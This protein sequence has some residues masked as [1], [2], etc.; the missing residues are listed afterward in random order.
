MKPGQSELLAALLGLAAVAVTAL[1]V[2]PAPVEHAPTRSQSQEL[3]AARQLVAAPV[4][5]LREG[6]TVAQRAESLVRVIGRSTWPTDSLLV[7]EDSL[8][9]DWK[10]DVARTLVR[11]SWGALARRAGGVRVVVAIM[12]DTAWGS[13][14]EADPSAILPELLDGHTC[15]VQLPRARVVGRVEKAGRAAQL[16]PRYLD[17]EMTEAPPGLGFDGNDVAALAWP[18]I[19][20]SLGACGWMAGY[21]APGAGMRAWLDSTG[22]RGA[23][24]ARF[25]DTPR[26]KAPWRF[27]YAP[28]A[29]SEFLMFA[30]QAPDAARLPAYSCA[31]RSSS[32]CT[33]FVSVGNAAAGRLASQGIVTAPPRDFGYSA[34]GVSALD[35]R[36]RF[37]DD[38][39]RAIGDDRFS[40]LW[41]D[42]RPFPDAFAAATGASLDSWVQRW[43]Y[44]AI[45][46]S[47]SSGPQVSAASLLI[48]T[49][50][51]S[52]LILLMLV[53]ARRRQ[54]G[55]S[56]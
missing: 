29:L 3:L 49:P 17:E 2:T 4:L 19:N 43:L 22:W 25:L 35:P 16:R 47:G 18:A 46:G 42:A 44:D 32:A 30:M 27:A 12:G 53:R 11:R 8:L 26:A 1:V 34:L 38:V 52:L 41:R 9:P 54:V 45:R 21:G 14:S 6:A 13:A 50:P 23:S 56:E 31:S 51:M 28:P 15:L 24:G 5:R 36:P 48:W 10:R 55:R 37:L 20:A 7:L 40:A 39:R 33:T